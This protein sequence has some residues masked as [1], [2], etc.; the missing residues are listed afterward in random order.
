MN[1]SLAGQQQPSLKKVLGYASLFAAAMGGVASQGS[2]VSLLNGAGTGGGAFFIA[3]LLAF[4][5]MICYVFTYLELSL[6]MPK[7]GG[8]GT[9][10]TVALGHFPAIIMVLAGYIFVQPFGGVAELSLL[11]NI[12]D[13]VYPGTFSHLSLIVFSLLTILN[14]MGINIFSSVQNTVVSIL[15]I[16]AMFIGVAGLNTEGAKGQEPLVLWHQLVNPGNSVFSLMVLVLWS[17]AGLEFV[18]PLLEET[19]SP[20]KNLPKVMIMAALMLLVIYGLIAYAGLTQVPAAQMANSDIPHWLL[21]NALFG[22]FGKWL[23]AVFAFTATS[24]IAN[25]VIAGLPRMM[26]G[27]AHH[28]QLPGIFKKLHPRWKTPWAGTLFLYVSIAIPLSLKG[29][30]KDLVLEMLISATVLWLMA[31]I[32]AHVNVM[33]LRQKY[34]NFRRPFKT[35]LY[36]LPQI[37]GI[38]GMAY[39]IFENS[40]SPNMSAKVYFNT[41]L[42]MGIAVIY[43]FFWVRFKMKQKLFEAEPIEEAIAD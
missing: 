41:G 32:I 8:P 24:C 19:K 37:I 11:D 17:F 35:P 2:F 25:A 10:T 38:L 22:K 6:M 4:V 30:A 27:M 43:G 28:K 15:I 5:L 40:P 31:Y 36:P 13:T 18:C 16:A 33:V 42:M 29:D 21:V 14:L 26:Y 3:I 20:E 39:A 1:N 34:K 9:Y 12:V 23:M 7:A